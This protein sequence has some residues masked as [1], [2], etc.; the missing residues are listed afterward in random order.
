MNGTVLYVKL[1][2]VTS[3]VKVFLA[4]APLFIVQLGLLFYKVGGNVV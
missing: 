2:L 1:Y 4:S 3:V